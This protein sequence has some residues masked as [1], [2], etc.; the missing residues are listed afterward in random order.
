[1]G[2]PLTTLFPIDLKENKVNNEVKYIETL[3]KIN[4][5]SDFSSAEYCLDW[6]LHVKI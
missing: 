2:P 1:M 6:L 3:K 4:S 5:D